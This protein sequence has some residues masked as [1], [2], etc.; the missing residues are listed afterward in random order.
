MWII[1]EA[2][3]I[4]RMGDDILSAIEFSDQGASLQAGVYA[5][6]QFERTVSTFNT[7]PDFNLTHQKVGESWEST[8]WTDSTI[9]RGIDSGTRIRRVLMSRDWISKTK[10]GVL[11]PGMGRGHAIFTTK[12]MA[13]PGIEPR[14]FSSIIFQDVADKILPWYSVFFDKTIQK[15]YS[16]VYPKRIISRP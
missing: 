3:E 11:D 7:K 5:Q 4:S 13:L 15:F 8:V 9:Y 14:G 1:I 6:S 10:P 12:A 2:D 16:K